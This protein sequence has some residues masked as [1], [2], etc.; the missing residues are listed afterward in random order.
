MTQHA[1]VDEIIIDLVVQRRDRGLTDA[2]EHAIQQ[3]ALLD[4]NIEMFGSEAQRVA[5][6]GRADRQRFGIENRRTCENRKAMA[7]CVKRL[8]L[9]DICFR[10]KFLQRQRFFQ[11][12]ANRP[13]TIPV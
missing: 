13:A 1:L 12:R 8:R 11:S 7:K 10:G 3:H 9:T 2:I 5:E 4:G 6:I